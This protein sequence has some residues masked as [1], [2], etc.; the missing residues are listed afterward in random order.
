M[1][2]KRDY[3][4]WKGRL[5]QVIDYNPALQVW[6]F[7]YNLVDNGEPL[8]DVYV[9]VYFYFHKVKTPCN[10]YPSK[11][12]ENFRYSDFPLLSPLS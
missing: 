5:E 3:I 4:D 6:K 10:L 12:T 8:K 2:N 9:C 7:G 1:E 11:V